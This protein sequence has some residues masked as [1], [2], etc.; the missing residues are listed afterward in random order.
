MTNWTINEVA[1]ACGLSRH[2]ISKWISMGLFRPSMS[3][4][5]G[6]WRRYDWRDVVCLAVVDQLRRIT[7]DT[8]TALRFAGDELRHG[9]AGY[10]NLPPPPVHWFICEFDHER[11]MRF[12]PADPVAAT[13][14]EARTILAVDVARVGWAA[15]RRLETA[16]E[17]RSG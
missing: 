1:T 8:G 2:E 13:V 12:E 15:L 3:T 5:R 10:E 7:I 6:E 4:R 11:R 9:L 16:S 17:V 14:A